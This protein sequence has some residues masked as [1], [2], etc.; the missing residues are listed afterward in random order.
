MRDEREREWR[1]RKTK[2][3]RREWGGGGGKREKGEEI[4]SNF[5]RKTISR[6]L[7]FS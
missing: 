1:D 2:R 7:I 5:K 4:D 6:N 3:E